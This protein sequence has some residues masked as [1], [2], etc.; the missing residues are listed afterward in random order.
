MEVAGLVLAIIPLCVTA[1]ERHETITRGRKALFEY[2]ALYS[3]FAEDLNLCLVELDQSVK[4]VLRAA[5]ISE[6]DQTDSMIKSC[7]PESWT[8][9]GQESKLRAHFGESQYNGGFVAILRKIQKELLVICRNLDVLPS[10]P[11][12]SDKVGPRDS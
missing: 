3:S 12:N 11:M 8:G 9:T 5:G 10:T 1:L 2:Q 4:R 7:R 6:D